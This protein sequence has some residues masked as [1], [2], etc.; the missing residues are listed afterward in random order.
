MSNSV[1]APAAASNVS[2]TIDNPSPAWLAPLAELDFLTRIERIQEDRALAERLADL[3]QVLEIKDEPATIEEIAKAIMTVFEAQ[4]KV[5][6]SETALEIWFRRMA[7]MPRD[8][9]GHVT[10][11]ILDHVY[12]TPTLADF[13]GRARP[14]IARRQH[15]KSS[16]AF[17]LRQARQRQPPA[18][19]PERVKQLA[20]GAVKKL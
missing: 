5:V 16:V 13:M 3:L 12:S 4:S 7:G 9:L 19:M 17:W 15:V 6:P 2:I 10:T 14:L 8:I 1:V 11:E 20:R 18:D